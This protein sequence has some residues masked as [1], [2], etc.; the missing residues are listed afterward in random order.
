[1]SGCYGPPDLELQIGFDEWRR[2]C[3]ERVAEAREM[4]MRTMR[5]TEFPEY[6]VV[7]LDFWKERW[8]GGPAAEPWLTWR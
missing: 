7:R 8:A 6:R 5:A 2:V 1:M 3:G 4:G